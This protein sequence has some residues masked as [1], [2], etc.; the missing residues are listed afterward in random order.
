MNLSGLAGCAWSYRN[1]LTDPGERRHCESLGMQRCCFRSFI[2]L[3]AVATPPK[4]ENT[5]ETLVPEGGGA[6]N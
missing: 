2:S 1:I 4:H 3:G 5:Y 6:G